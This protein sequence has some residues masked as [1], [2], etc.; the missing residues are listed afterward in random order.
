M[1]WTKIAFHRFFLCFVSRR[2]RVFYRIHVHVTGRFRRSH[3]LTWIAFNMCGRAFDRR[4]KI[5]TVEIV[6]CTPEK[7]SF[8]DKRHFVRSLPNVT[9]SKTLE[10]TFLSLFHSKNNK[11]SRGV[12][13][14]SDVAQFEKG[15]I[16]YK[17]DA[18]NSVIKFWNN[19]CNYC[20]WSPCPSEYTFLRECSFLFNEAEKCRCLKELEDC[21]RRGAIKVNTSW[22]EDLK[23]VAAI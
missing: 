15:T 9:Q 7:L 1:I 11:R 10:L 4:W 2:T 12:R 8:D 5:Y 13:A 23:I 18:I 22:S 3:G 17:C 20:R 21:T 14:T 6:I 16:S 19:T